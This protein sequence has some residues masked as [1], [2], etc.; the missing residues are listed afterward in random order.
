MLLNDIINLE[1]I[2][3]TQKNTHHRQ[4]SLIPKKR[5][6]EALVNTKTKEKGKDITLRIPTIITSKNILGGKITYNRSPQIPENNLSYFRSQKMTSGNNGRN[7][8][9]K[10]TGKHK[11]TF[12]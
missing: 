4:T 7:K 1:E 9:K 5:Y 2:L 10:Q 11:R 8:T 3:R 6:S 12:K